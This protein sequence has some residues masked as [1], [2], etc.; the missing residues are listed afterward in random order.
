MLRDEVGRIAAIVVVMVGVVVRIQRRSAIEVSWRIATRRRRQDGIVTVIVEAVG[1]RTIVVTRTRRNAVDHP[2]LVTGT[3][4]AE[5]H[6]LEIFKGSEAIELVIQ[7]IVRHHR[8]NP[9][10]IWTI[11]RNG[12]RNPSDATRAH[13][14]V[15][16]AIAVTIV[17]IEVDI[18]IA[19]ISVVSDILNIIVDGDRIGVIGQHGL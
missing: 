4:P 2:W 19:T 13:S 1:I 11:G 7:F 5:A 16:R 9:G 14:H 12:D 17:G 18:E 3:I 15:L 6:G 10:G 8:I